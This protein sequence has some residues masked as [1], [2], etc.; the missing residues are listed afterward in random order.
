MGDATKLLPCPFCG[1]DGDVSHDH[2]V[3]ECHDYGCR[4]CGIWFND[5]I[6][7]DPVKAWNTRDFSAAI[8]N[9]TPGACQA[10]II[11]AQRVPR[12]TDG[13]D[14]QKAMTEVLRR[15]FCDE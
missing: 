11:A 7:D 8:D 5:F 12:Q 10:I 4:S 1:G 15:V 13:N 14:H 6:A 3:E 2:T 9:L